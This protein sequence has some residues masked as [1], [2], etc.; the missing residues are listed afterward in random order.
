MKKYDDAFFLLNIVDA[1]SDILFYTTCTEE[2][3]LIETM[4][5]DAV[6]RKFENLGEAVK[7]LSARF[8]GKYPQIPWS[9]IARFRDVLSHHY[10]GIDQQTVWSIARNDAKDAY[11]AISKLEE[12][13]KAMDDF[14]RKQQEKL[15]E[16]RQKK[17]EIYNIARKHN[18]TRLFVFGACSRQ[19]D[20]N[21]VADFKDA[22]L[23]DLAALTNELEQ[24]L[25]RRIAIFP[26]ASLNECSF[27]DRVRK[28]MEL[29]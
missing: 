22:S 20:L 13:V 8:C 15:Q 25:D 12:Y 10:F 6:A 3:F 5:Q 16:L 14:R 26:L 17:D 7:N 24:F 18:V 29:L 23:L 11:E 1:L 28:E 19:N 21:F 9:H 4:R 27:G 2:Q